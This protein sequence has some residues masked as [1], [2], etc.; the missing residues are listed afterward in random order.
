MYIV[1]FMPHNFY[2]FIQSLAST[3]NKDASFV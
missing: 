3:H 1:Y 2:V